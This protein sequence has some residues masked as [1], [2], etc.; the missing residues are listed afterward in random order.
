MPHPYDTASQPPS[1]E[2]IDLQDY[3][4]EQVDL[5]I[6]RTPLTAQQLDTTEAPQDRYRR[7]LDD[8]LLRD[9]VGNRPQ[10]GLAKPNSHDLRRRLTHS[11]REA[12]PL[13]QLIA[14]TQHYGGPTVRI[15]TAH[16]YDAQLISYDHGKLHLE[17]C[18]ACADD[19]AAEII[20]KIHSHEREMQRIRHDICT[21]DDAPSAATHSHPAHP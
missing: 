12:R 4:Q 15:R 13:A 2:L 11:R 19:A 6:A 7:T 5:E 1:R 20:A 3:L 18:G 8:G 9:F 14:L 21:A 10:R 17:G 16:A